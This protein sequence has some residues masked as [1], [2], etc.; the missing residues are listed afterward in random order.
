MSA[1]LP[2]SIGAKAV[3]ESIHAISHPVQDQQDLLGDAG[4]D[5]DQIVVSV[6]TRAAIV[7]VLT[8]ARAT[9]A[10]Q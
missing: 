9:D 2:N 5:A 7:P 6:L 8:R 3:L 10:F 4:R 1:I